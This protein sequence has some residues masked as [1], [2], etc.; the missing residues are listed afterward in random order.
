M[1]TI[2]IGSKLRD[3]PRTLCGDG[4]PTL[5]IGSVGTS[6]SADSLEAELEKVRAAAHTGAHVVT[7]HSFYGDIPAFHKAI[8]EHVDVLLSTVACYE[9]A[10]A[11]ERRQWRQ[12][13]PGLPIEMLRAQ[14]DRG[15]DL[16]T[17]HASLRKA[18]VLAAKD[19]ARTIPTT[20]KGGGIM[21][22]YMR[23]TGRE[24]PYFERFDAVLDLFRS[25]GAALSLGTTFRSATVVDGWDSD[26][27]TEIAVMGDLVRRA[28]EAGVPVMVEGLGHADIGAIPTYIRLTKIK[29]AGAPYR[30]LPMATD[31]ALG[32]DHISGAIATAVAVAN[33][34]DA[35]TAMSRAEHIGLPTLADM[36]EGLIATKVAAAAGELLKVGDFAAEHQMSRTRWAHGCK[37]DW[38]TAVH[39]DGA[40][41]ALAERGRLNDQLIKCGMCGDFC[42]IASGIATV[43]LSARK[44][45]THR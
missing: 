4:A 44:P 34:A 39:P 38:T 36:E 40:E 27:A 8:A 32:Y 21:S 25:R 17:L 26:M 10:A 31:R 41:R 18:D 33:G 22:S 2:G 28:H 37:G 1:R 13:D 12:V 11:H 43:K 42:G 20:S 16:V 7:D 35:V 3:R 19:S 6:R 9:F 15:V 14:L 29:C 45:E 5:I 23:S 30:I 24:N